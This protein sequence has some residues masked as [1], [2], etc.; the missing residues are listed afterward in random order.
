MATRYTLPIT[1]EEVERRLNLIPNLATQEDVDESISALADEVDKKYQKPSGGIPKADLASGVRS[2]LDKADTALQS[3]QDISGKADKTYVDTELAKKAT[4][5][6]VSALTNR[7][8]AVETSVGDKYTKPSAGI[9]K[10]D[11]ASGVQASLDKADSA[12]QTH[13]DI[14]GKADKSYVDSELAT[15]ASGASVTALGTRVSAVETS[16]NARY[17]KPS[18]GIPKG[19]LS[20]SVQTSLSRADSALQSVPSTYR[21]ASEQDEIDEGK[22]DKL[23]SGTSI[24]TINGQSLLGSGNIN[25]Q[26]GGGSDVNV[27]DDLQSE[28]STDALSARQGKILKGMVDGKASQDEVD[29]LSGNLAN[30][31]NKTTSAI[32]ETLGYTPASITSVEDLQDSLETEIA[33]KQD[34]ISDLES[35]RSGAGLGA[36]AVQPSAISDM[37]TKTHASATYQPKGSYATQSEVNAKYTKPSGGIPKTDLASAVQTSLS[38]ADTALQ[39]ADIADLAKDSEVVHLTGDESIAG[40]KYFADSCT[41]DADWTRFGGD[42][43]AD[44]DIFRVGYASPEEGAFHRLEAIE[45]KEAGWDGKQDAISDLST[46]RSGA[47]LGATALQSYT[48][49]DPVFNA[50]PAKTITTAN[51]NAWNAKADKP[52]I[53]TTLPTTLVA[54]TFYNLGTLTGS[55]TIKIPT[56]YT[57]TDEFMLQF[58]TGSTAP[59]ITWSIT[60]LKWAGGSAPTI[61]ANKTYQV[62]IQNNLGIIVEF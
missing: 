12:L 54:N 59:T 60:G 55:K 36:T 26:G 30:K 53:A 52:T 18:T 27:V 25:V 16:V 7:V 11:L 37:E 4:T 50:S 34:T 24:K 47:S 33:E 44:T 40:E 2:S 20:A 49:T 58:T 17:T 32:I 61:N 48:E 15:K 56:S 22:Q 45:A 8:G 3:H 10:T 46:I 31:M 57:A 28:S 39:S 13:Q 51:I 23:V 29:T 19:D 38:K 41:F 35:I 62:S 6:S 42:I 9:P 21:T 43:I 1:G 14:S 5:A